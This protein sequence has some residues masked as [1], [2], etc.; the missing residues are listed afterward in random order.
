MDFIPAFD[1]A[2]PN[3]WYYFGKDS[4]TGLNTESPVDRSRDRARATL[5]YRAFR[6]LHRAMFERQGF[7]FGPM[8]TLAKTIDGSPL[9][10]A[11]TRFEYFTKEI[12]NECMHCGD[13]IM[14]DLGYL[15]PSS[16][17]PKNQRN[18]PCG[19]SFEGWCE[20]YPGKRQCIY[21]RAYPNLKNSGTEDSLGADQ[22]PPVNYD[23]FQTS[24]WLNFFLGRGHAAK[25]Q[26]IL[27]IPPAPGAPR[28]G[29]RNRGWW[30]RR[31]G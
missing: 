22:T 4:K 7:L 21:V 8:R 28:A 11:F 16:Q 3:G 23:L 20:V 19:G 27:P 31:R 15:C 17:C 6:V 10:H 1:F 26:G 5:G 12:T 14:F 25:R 13:C 2:Q 30:Q 9:E 29:G 18:G 24:S